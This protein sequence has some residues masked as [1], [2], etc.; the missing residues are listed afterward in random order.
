MR[1]IYLH[2]YFNTP[3][4]SGGTRSYEM[5]KRLVAYG[6][7]VHIITSWREDTVETKWFTTVESGIHVHWQPVQYSNNMS[8][9]RRIVSFFKF[10][11]GATIKARAINGDVVFATST[12]LT[13]AI[14]GVFV[15][16]KLKVPMVFEVRDLWPELPIAIGALK[17]PMLC[18]LAKWLEKWAY[19]HSSAI[20]ALSP[21][22]K[23]GVVKTGYPTNKVAT[24]PNISDL[25]S[26]QY[27]EVSSKEFRRDNSWLQ[28]KPLLVY[29]GTFGRI[30]GVVYLVNIA[31]HLK[32]I[33]PDLRILL[34]GHGM[35]YQLVRDMAL[36]LGVLNENLFIQ[37]STPKKKIP[38]ILSAANIAC[39]LCIDLPEL[40]ANSAN[41]FFD[42]LAAG[43]PIMLNYGGWQ[44]EL[45]ERFNAGLVT[46][47][48]QYDVAAQ[49]IAV[50]LQDTDWQKSAGMAARDL[51]KQLFDKDVLAKQL[52]QV[53]VSA[54]D[55]NTNE[56][57]KISPGYY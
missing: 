30:N 6:H 13:I 55:Q 42:A 52:E 16:K 15:S 35:E 17:N 57:Y 51:A 10:A 27:D 36:K 33:A 31:V 48:M 37:G 18:Y 38:M 26:F 28:D 40:R 21:G 7:E 24:I 50:A 53:L 14:P 43:K 8:F 41:K 19:K 39:S 23:D 12:P 22:M 47:G 20:V 3:E 25:D 4:M 1:I 11:I 9:S 34:V 49:Q 46:W 32:K 54:V 29:T 45:I 44:A 2:Q 5:A 56:I